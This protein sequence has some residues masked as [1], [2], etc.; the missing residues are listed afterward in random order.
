M[1]V[2]GQVTISIEDF[3]K[4]K[5]AADHKE[6]AGSQLEAFRERMQNFYEIEDK[7]FW[8]KVDEIDK[9]SG[10][11]TERQINKALSEA[12]KTLKI[13]VDPDALKKTLAAMIDES[14]HES[15]DTH[16]DLKYATEK[17]LDAIEICFKK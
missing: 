10:G 1:E 2:K 17:E 15:N 16:I 3:E 5:E 11:M 14:K 12:R 4:L 6:Y 7:E 9:K 8:E 13:V